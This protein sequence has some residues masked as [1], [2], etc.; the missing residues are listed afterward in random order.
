MFFDNMFFEKVCEDV[1]LEFYEWI[2]WVYNQPPIMA[3]AYTSAIEEI[4]RFHDEIGFDCNL[5]NIVDLYIRDEERLDI[6]FIKEIAA[7]FSPKGLFKEFGN[8]YHKL[9]RYGIQTYV[10]FLEDKEEVLVQ[11]SKNYIDEEIKKHLKQ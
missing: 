6:A 10:K 11:K 2:L 4:N 3:R 1:D 7:D 5:Y 9:I 8:R